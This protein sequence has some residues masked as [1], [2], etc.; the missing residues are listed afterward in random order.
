MDPKR[1]SL[2]ISKRD[3]IRI[4]QDDITN[5]YEV[6]KKLGEGSYGKIYKAKNKITGDI[7]AMKQI[8]K[9]KITDLQTFK[10]EIEILSRMD[11]PNIIKL[12]E[13]FEDSKYFYLI[14]EL[15]TGGELLDRIVKRKT[16][17]PFTEREAA[18]I[19]KQLVSAISYC[20]D[21]G[22]V[23]RDLKPE[24]ILFINEEPNSPIKV[25]DFGFSKEFNNKNPK[26]KQKNMSSKVGTVYYISPEILQG[27]Y[28][29]LCDIW[30]CGVILYII[31]CGYPPFQGNNDKEIY[32]SIQSGKVDFPQKEWKSISKNAKDLILKM[33][34]PANK[35]YNAKQVLK[36][37]WVNNKAPDSKGE[38]KINVESLLNFKKSNKLRK[39][40]L[41]FIA[42][43]LSDEEVNNIKQIF[44]S[45]DKDKKGTITLQELKNG[46]EQSFSP[47]EHINI[48]E[49]FDSIDTDHSGRID[50]TEF[51]AATMDQKLY[52]KDEK[53]Y[54]AFNAFDPNS[55]G[56][57]SIKDI[58]KFLNL[59]DNSENDT[60]IQQWIKEND[61]NGDGVVDFNEFKKMMTK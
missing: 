61:V 35:R 53:L 14:N 31:L 33:L 52:L 7:R 29:E 24:N 20:H 42:S 55:T 41:T 19:F 30:S 2:T 9:S 36:H 8:E 48:E 17:N 34:C 51:I 13:V 56:K 37:N 18:I 21:I 10:N 50:Y 27:N 3:F 47:D 38:L 16:E 58:K 6:I 26:N 44:S 15:C 25:I 22:I 12:F 46:L 11:H 45:M 1:K 57:I 43:R 4:I 60:I 40:V 54:E 49:L 32:K 28:N 59:Q 23:H 39:V 5:H